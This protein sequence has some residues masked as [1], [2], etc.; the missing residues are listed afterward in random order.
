MHAIS[1]HALEERIILLRHGP[2]ALCSIGFVSAAGFKSWAAAYERS[3]V[4]PQQ[5]PLSARMAAASVLKAF[6]SERP[7]SRQS[8]AALGL[9]GPTASA[10]FNEPALPII[11]V[12]GIRLPITTWLVACRALWLS[13]VLNKGES[14]TKSRQRGRA[15]ARLLIANSK[16]GVAL[17]GH[18]WI[19]R[20]ISDELQA[21]GWHR[22]CK[23]SALWGVSSYTPP[24]RSSL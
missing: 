5:P 9:V 14:V 8:A 2:V 1:H 10:I 11:R 15:A 24:D 7:R 23:S 12:P 19:N 21:A 3:D 16:G 4:I 6:T 18:G 17:V 20:F 22:S 13:G